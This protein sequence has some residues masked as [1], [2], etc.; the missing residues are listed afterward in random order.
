M[1]DKSKKLIIA[2][3]FDGCI[4][5]YEKGWHDGSIYGHVVPGFWEWAEEAEKHYTLVIFSTRCREVM[6]TAFLHE[7]LDRK[8]GEHCLAT[9][10]IRPMPDFA[11]SVKKP[12]AWLTIDDRAIT[13]DGNWSKFT[14]EFID[15]FRPWYVPKE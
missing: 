13:F 3:D 15:G 10:H 2:L 12:M 9:G 8:H 5:S 4:H 14:R 7:W 6:D 1:S 11:F